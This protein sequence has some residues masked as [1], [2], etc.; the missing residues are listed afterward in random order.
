MQSINYLRGR[1][2]W[3]VRNFQI[4]G[5]SDATRF[6]YLGVENIDSTNRLMFG[7]TGI[8]GSVQDVKFSNLIDFRGNNLPASISSPK[9][10]IRY[11]STYAAF[12]IGDE[13]DAGFRIA[14]DNN[15]P[16]PVRV[17]LFIYEMGA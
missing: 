6:Y 12:L 16:G 15:A 1:R 8:G 9:I 14:R 4:W 3:V 5:T 11:R 10:I 17:D 2:L 7:T 13:S